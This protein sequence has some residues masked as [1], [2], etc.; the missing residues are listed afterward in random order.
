MTDRERDRP[1]A[2]LSLAQGVAPVSLWRGSPSGEMVSLRC[3][4]L[5]RETV[6][7]A[8]PS[9]VQWF[10]ER[11]RPSAGLC[12]AVVFRERISRKQGSG[13][14]RWNGAQREAVCWGRR[15]R[16]MGLWRANTSRLMGIM[17][18]WGKGLRLGFGGTLKN[19]D[20]DFFPL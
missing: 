3:G 15:S 17:W 16:R 13:S 9:L 4:S 11:D 6:S 1:S 20:V 12:L 18:K 14:P 5:S 8:G 19:L 2:G 7:S 10:V